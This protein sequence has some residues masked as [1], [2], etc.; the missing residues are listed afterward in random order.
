MIVRIKKDRHYRSNYILRPFKIGRTWEKHYTVVFD[1]ST[2]YELEENKTQV[3]KLVGV[4][5]LFHHFNSV[6][7]GWR[8]HEGVVELFAYRYQNGQRTYFRLLDVKIGE[9]VDIRIEYKIKGGKAEYLMQVGNIVSHYSWRIDKWWQCIPFVYECFPYF[10][11]I[12]PSPQNIS[13]NIIK[14]NK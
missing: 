3:N 1:D 7:I 6:R 13:I 9:S 11:G 14:V 12:M 10:G 8:Y 4:G 5:H 2:R